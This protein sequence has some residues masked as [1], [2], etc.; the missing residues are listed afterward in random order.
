VD[1]AAPNEDRDHLPFAQHHALIIGINAYEGRRRRPSALRH[2]Q[3]LKA[4]IPVGVCVR[5]QRQAVADA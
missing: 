5:H 2:H 3:S 1:V 4:D